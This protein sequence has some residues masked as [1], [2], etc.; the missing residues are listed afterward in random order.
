MEAAKWEFVNFDKPVKEQ[1]EASQKL[2]RAAAMRAF[3][4]KERLRRIETFQKTE[5]G[6][7]VV[8][9]FSGCIIS[10]EKRRLTSQ[11]TQT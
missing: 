9:V 6:T 1:G 2:V 10:I 11:R 4:R 8:E 5:V 3:R 7:P